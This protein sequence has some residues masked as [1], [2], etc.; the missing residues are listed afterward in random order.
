M[1]K[2]IFSAAVLTV[3][4]AGAQAALVIPN[5]A[6]VPTG[7]STDRYA[8]ASFANVGSFQGRDNVLGIGI[9]SAQNA[10]NRGAQSAMF[11]NTQ[12]DQ[13][14]ISGGAGST[15]GAALYIDTSWRDAANGW[16]RSDMWG[17]M[18]DSFG[19]TDYP[20]I[21]FTNQDGNARYRVYD[22][23]VLANGGWIDINTTVAFG[24]WTA[25]QMVYN[26]G[27]SLDYFID[28]AL[29]YTDNTIGY[30][31]PTEGFSAVIM[32]AYNYGDPAK[33]P[34]AVVADYTAHWSNI[35]EPATLALFGLALAGLAVTRRRKA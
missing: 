9:S 27:Y 25:F 26:G 29:V 15:L 19:I 23:D 7:W 32:Q 28:G 34:N 24:S 16:V 35:P 17:V 6:D 20:I 18:S 33:F 13:H 8:P 14:A 3:A 10:A 22:G 21:G 1:F 30:G 4:V 31:E 2:S 12:G 11:Y 5:F